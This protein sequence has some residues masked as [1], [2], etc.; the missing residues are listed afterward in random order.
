M[1]ALSFE[2]AQGLCDILIGMQPCLNG[3][4]LKV[5][6]EAAFED[7]IRI[8]PDTDWPAVSEWLRSDEQDAWKVADYLDTAL[9]RKRS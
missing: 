9:E 5:G 4:Y 7:A 2:D 8:W 3:A 1:K 6:M